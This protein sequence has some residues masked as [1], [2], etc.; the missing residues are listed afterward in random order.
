MSPSGRSHAPGGMHKYFMRLESL[1]AFSP[2]QNTTYEVCE[3]TTGILFQ[4]AREILNEFANGEA[5]THVLAHPG[6]F[7]SPQPDGIL[8]KMC[9]LVAR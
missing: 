4:C 3:S 5:L 2:I 7:G 1:G 8:R 6:P 9:S